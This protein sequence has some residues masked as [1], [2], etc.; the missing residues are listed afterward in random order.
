MFGL[1][2][3]ELLVVLVIALVIFGP[4]KLPKVGEALG[5]SIREFKKA[6]DVDLDDEDSEDE[7][8]EKE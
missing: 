2:L 8:E 4:A 5:K 1:G 3:P 7:N 6:T